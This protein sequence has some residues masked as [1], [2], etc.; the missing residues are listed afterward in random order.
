MQG[1]AVKMSD[2]SRGAQAHEGEANTVVGG[3]GCGWF[4]ANAECMVRRR[5]ASE[6]WEWRVGLRE[7]IRLCWS[8]CLLA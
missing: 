2:H 7:C 1:T 8:S 4:V 5:F 6:K 3:L